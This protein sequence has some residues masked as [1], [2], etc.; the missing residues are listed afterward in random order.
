MTK[1]GR[2][3][4]GKLPPGAIAEL[5]KSVA[6]YRK[7]ARSGVRLGVKILPPGDCPV[8][9]AQKEAVYSLDGVPGLPLPGCNRLPCCGCCYS[10]VVKT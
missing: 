9:A 1:L 4:Q 2:E 3:Y 8:A 10:P 7:A 6:G 5:R